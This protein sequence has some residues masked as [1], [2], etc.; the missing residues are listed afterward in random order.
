VEGMCSRS[1]EPLRIGS[2]KK[3][4][5]GKVGNELLFLYIPYSYSSGWVPCLEACCCG[6][7]RW[8]RKKKVCSGNLPV[9]KKKG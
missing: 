4:F 3:S 7:N 9:G 1:I 5:T 2:I 6:R 8:D